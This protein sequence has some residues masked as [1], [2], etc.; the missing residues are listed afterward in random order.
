MRAVGR[1]DH[2]VQ[3]AFQSKQ[4]REDVLRDVQAV[5]GFVL[6]LKRQVVDL[7]AYGDAQ[8]HTARDHQHERQD[9]GK[10]IRAQ[11]PRTLFRWTMNFGIVGH[12][13]CFTKGDRQNAESGE[14]RGDLAVTVQ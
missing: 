3:G 4:R 10:Q 7:G 5:V 2:F 11:R 1:V 8:R 9:Q 14:F 13:A 12:I 6:K